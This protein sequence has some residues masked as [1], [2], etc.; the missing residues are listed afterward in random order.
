MKLIKFYAPWCGPCKFI[1]PLIDSFK[2]KLNIE[3][4]N[5]DEDK[6]LALNYGIRSIPAIVVLHDNGTVLET[7][8]GAGEI[9]KVKLN[10]LVKL[11]NKV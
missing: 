11:N 4:V 3:S 2:D 5:I 10:K 7:L 6:S 1:D 8:N 9:T